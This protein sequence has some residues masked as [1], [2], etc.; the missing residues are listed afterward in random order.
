MNEILFHYEKIA[1]TTWAYLSSLLIVGLF[2]KFGR[3]WSVRNLDLLLLILLA[4]GLFASEPASPQT[5]T[6]ERIL[7]VGNSFTYFNNSLH[8]HLRKLLAAGNPDTRDINFLKA[9]TISGEVL[10]N[11]E[12]GL[13]HMLDVYSWDVVVLQGHSLEAVDPE[14]RPGL[15]AAAEKYVGMI[16]EK[17]ARPVI[18]MT[19]AYQDRP[20][21]TETLK[22]VYAELGASL[23]VMVVPVGLAF[24]DA[25][26]SIP[27]LTLHHPDKIHPSV[28]G[29]Y[30]AACVFYAAL[31]GKSPAGFGYTAGLDEHVALK[32]Q[33]SAWQTVSGYY[34]HP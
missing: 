8:G 26:E 18:F 6:P 31:F 24:A 13:R 21:M 12:G 10:A 34:H 30:L 2:F 15:E 7:F 9:M 25:L 23:G 4:P 1:P 20:G 11:H 32:L 3:F 29:S 22:A 28:E 17:N 16:R 5:E 14:K 33:Q 27:G 19:W